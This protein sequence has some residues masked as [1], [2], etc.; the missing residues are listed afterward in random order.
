MG[1]R[2]SPRE[3]ALE[4]SLSNNFVTELTSLVV[5]QPEGKP[6][7]ALLEEKE[8]HRIRHGYGASNFGYS[9]A[10]LKSFVR[11]PAQ[12]LNTFG[13]TRRKVANRQRPQYIAYSQGQNVQH[14][15]SNN[16]HTTTTTTQT[17]TS[18]F[19]T[20][21]F[22]TPQISPVDIPVCSGNITLFSSNYHR[23]ENITL[24]DIKN[25]DL[26]SMNNKTVS[27]KVE[28]DCCWRLFMESQFTG[29]SKLVSSQETYISVTSLGELR[30]KVSSVRQEAC[31]K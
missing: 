31:Y 5:V 12:S 19:T 14:Q 23:G 8:S 10:N 15:N 9:Q 25:H 4:L 26:G 21:T 20:T 18:T 24:V 28:G 17:T 6:K 30:R 11:S 22:P 16:F 2:K 13:L 3:R 29:Q 27:V 7:I 1:T